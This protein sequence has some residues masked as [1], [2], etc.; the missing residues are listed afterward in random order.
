VSVA[1]DER[2]LTEHNNKNLG[3]IERKGEKSELE[4]KSAPYEV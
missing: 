4:V 3:K 1:H 2:E